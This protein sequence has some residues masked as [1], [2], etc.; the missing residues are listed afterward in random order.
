MR[1]WRFNPAQRNG[2]T[3]PASVDIPISFDLQ[4]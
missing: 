1:H 2:Q 4:R 3:L